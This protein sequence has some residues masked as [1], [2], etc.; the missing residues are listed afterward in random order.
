MGSVVV[1]EQV[2]PGGG[3]VG[4]DHG[5]PPGVAQLT[6]DRG[7]PVVVGEG[8]GHL[9][10]EM[11]EVAQIDQVDPF[12]VAIPDP[13]AQLDGFLV[14]TGGLVSR[15]LQ[16]EGAGPDAGELGLSALVTRG[17]EDRHCLV[18]M[19]NRQRRLL[20]LDQG[21]RQLGERLG[22]TLVVGSR[23]IDRGLEMSHRLE[24]PTR[25]AKT[26]AEGHQGC[27]EPTPVATLLLDGHRETSRFLGPVEVTGMG[28]EPCPTSLEV[29]A[30]TI[31]VVNQKVHR[32]DHLGLLP[33]SA[34]DVEYRL[35][36]GEE[37][38]SLVVGPSS[39]DHRRPGGHEML[40]RGGVGIELLGP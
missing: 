8:I 40:A 7:R 38:M 14:G 10:H 19:G 29:A 20:N 6:E 17:S 32:A 16:T 27:G 36:A 13:T 33:T 30:P 3:G 28:A 35:E 21:A 26:G 31:P 9:T 22:P 1:P 12:S 4:Q 24:R 5:L 39:L 25:P 11:V 18:E 2:V 37:L 15:S 34:E 23:H